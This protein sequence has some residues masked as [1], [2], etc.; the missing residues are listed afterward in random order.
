MS[1]PAVSARDLSLRFPGIDG[2]SAVSAVRGVSLDI[3]PGETLA[4]LGEAGSGKSALARAVAGLTDR[5]IERGPR[6]VGGSLTVL[7]IDVR[8]L[9]RRDDN[10]LA[11]RVGYVP[12]DAGTALDPHLTA[13]ENVAYPLYQRTPKLDRVVAGG[14]VAEAIDAMHLTLATIPKYPHE[15]S[16][17]QRQRVA[18]ARALV[19]EPELLV[20]DEATSGVDAT[21][22][23]TILDH[24]AE[25]QRNRGFAALV[26]SSEIGEVR[27]LTTR[28]AV[29]HAGRFVGYGTI[30]EVLE[31]GMHPYVREL[32]ALGR[33][34]PVAV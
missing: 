22:R 24:L 30:D 33:R 11:L 14:I 21:V 7:G 3:A 16:R 8:G 29:M 6:I 18:I 32:A 31:T 28:L 23:S 4:I 1:T 5:T 26:V 2:A 15:L 13:G 10:E 12:Q 17:G 19:L 25:V 9:R 20:T 34:K 27:R